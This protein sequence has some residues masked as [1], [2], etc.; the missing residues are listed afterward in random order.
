MFAVAEKIAVKMH[1]VL[2]QNKK[3]FT[4]E[5]LKREIFFTICNILN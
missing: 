1:L 4:V 5:D 2:V 3:R